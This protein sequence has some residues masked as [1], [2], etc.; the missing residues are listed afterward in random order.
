MSSDRRV[1]LGSPDETL[2]ILNNSLNNGRKLLS[3]EGNVTESSNNSNDV[4][5][6]L[7][8]VKL[9]WVE[10]A[11]RRQSIAHRMLDVARQYFAFGKLFSIDDLAFS[12][13]TDEG[14]R[15]ACK[16]CGYSSSLKAYTAA[17]PL[18]MPTTSA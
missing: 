9:I 15:F 5:P 11:H 16:Y 7:L 4:N 14:F 18:S 3:H 1:W 17:P 6:I 10:E 13:P 2:G 12:Q 8:G